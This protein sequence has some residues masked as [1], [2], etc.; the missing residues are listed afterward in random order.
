MRT[1]LKTI[2]LIVLGLGLVL[3]LGF[4]NFAMASEVKKIAE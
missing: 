3:S 4:N 2:G 1:Q